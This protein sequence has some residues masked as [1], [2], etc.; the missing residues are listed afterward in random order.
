MTRSLQRMAEDA[1]GDGKKVGPA[2]EGKQRR[3]RGFISRLWSGVFGGRSEDFEKRLQYLSKEEASVMGRM[4]RRARTSKKRAFNVIL[5]TILVEL[6]FIGFAIV[7]V[8]GVDQTWQMKAVQV[9]PIFLVPALGFAVYTGFVSF[10]RMCDRKDQKTLERLR[11]ER[12]AKIDELKERTNYYSTQQLIQRYDL[13]PAAKAAAATVLASKLGA[14]SGLN[15][16]VGD[17]SIPSSPMGK[18]NDVELSQSTGLRNRKSSN[19]KSHSPRDTGN[20]QLTDVETIN[21]YEAEG[22]ETGVQH[23]KMVE[24]YRGP[25]NDSGILSG[26]LNFLVGDDPTHSYALICGNCRIHNG[27]ARKEDF[28]YMT[29]YCPHCHALNVSRLQQ[30]G[31]ES[32]SS[33][34]RTTPLGDGVGAPNAGNISPET[35]VQEPPAS[36]DKD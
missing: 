29:Y 6:V 5:M 24:H 28:P 22:K 18:S 32:S 21:E 7:M 12:K 8:R 15:F 31:R 11:A 14:D 4:Q 34:G 16:L 10:I 13:D 2:R 30:D 19:F 26:L 17:E 20:T 25:P 36:T 23:Q 9:L 3:R 27:L 1:A 33:S 35:T